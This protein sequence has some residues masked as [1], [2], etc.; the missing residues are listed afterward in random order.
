MGVYATVSMTLVIWVEQI[1]DWF[2][3][4]IQLAAI[5]ASMVNK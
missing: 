4:F 3:H 5:L 2:I 1:C